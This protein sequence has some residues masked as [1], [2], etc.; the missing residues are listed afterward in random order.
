MDNETYLTESGRTLADSEPFFDRVPED[1]LLGAMRD[2]IDVAR[3]LDL[4]KKS[5]FYGRSFDNASARF[6]P[7]LD[8]GKSVGAINSRLLHAAIGLA[9]ETGEIMEALE[10]TAVGEPLDEVNICEEIG[11]IE[12]YLAIAYRE[13]RT[14]P[15][16]EKARNIAK[17]RAAY[18]GRFTPELALARDRERER[19]VLE[20]TYGSTEEKAG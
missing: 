19:R 12:W 8:S 17:L 5:L 4:V 11:D 1:V 6:A 2:F 3:R 16:A 15:A 10:R 18:P 7:S 20:S 14:T 9:T 13:M